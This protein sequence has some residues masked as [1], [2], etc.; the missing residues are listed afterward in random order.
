AVVDQEQLHQQRR[1][2]KERHVDPGG[3]AQELEARE[4]HQ[5]QAEAQQQAEKHPAQAEDYRVV[6]ALEQKG[7]GVQRE[8]ETCF[9]YCVTSALKY[10][11][12]SVFNVPSARSLSR[13]LFTASSS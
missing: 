12:D 5:G 4:A 2:A 10:F 6:R 1:A 8:L 13:A 9:H 7:R 3:P 11:S